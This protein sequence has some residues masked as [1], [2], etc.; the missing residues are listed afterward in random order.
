M[1]LRYCPLQLHQLRLSTSRHLTTKAYSPRQCLHNRGA[2]FGSKL[3]TTNIFRTS[4]VLYRTTAALPRD[5]ASTLQQLPSVSID[6]LS[7]TPPTTGVL[8]YLPASWVPYAELTRIDK[9]TGTIYLLLPCLWSTLLAASMTLPTAPVSTVVTMSFLFTSGAFIMRGAG[10]TINDLWDRNI[11]NQVSRTRLRPLARRAITPTKAIIFAC[12]QL[13]TGL[14]ILV[15]FPLSVVIPAIPSV[16]AISVYPLMKR[17]THYPQVVLG[18]CFSWG[19]MLGF[20]AV[21]LSLAD[22]IVAGTAACLFASN[23]VWTV[24]YDT[25]YAHQDLKDDKKAGVKSTAIAYENSTKA[26]LAALAVGQ[27]GLLAGAGV[28]AS[29]G[30]P[31]FVGSCGGTALALGWMISR[32]NLK[33][34]KDCWRWFKW[35]AWAVGGGTVG[36]GLVGEYTADRKS[37]V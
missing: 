20:P 1:F 15:Q 2:G 34:A 10:C 4:L 6:S 13:L 24:L 30:A 28:V 8:A 17:Y 29:L 25:I 27:V 37:V 33:D 11:D 23:I 32:V 9:P 36:G 31:F 12:A 22:P 7:Y 14:G 16:A 18:I 5:A 19:A 26:F 3:L 21:G 35:C